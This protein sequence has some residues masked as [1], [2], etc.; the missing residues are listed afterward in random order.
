MCM[1]NRF[2]T[3]GRYATHALCLVSFCGLVWACKDDY[4][5]DDEKPGSLSSS[6][7]SFLQDKGNYQTYIRL[8]NDPAVNDPNARP[9]WEELS[10]TNEKTLFVANDEGWEAFFQKNATLPASDPW[11]TAT[12]YENLS[13]SQKK[14]LIH[15]SML[16]NPIVMENLASEEG[17]GSSSLQRGVYMRRE[18]SFM[19]TDTITFIP[20]EEIPFTYNANDKN[21]WRRFRPGN[22]DGKTG[23]HLV[24]DSTLNMLVFLT[25]EFL[26]KQAITNE[27]FSKVMGGRERDPED[28]FITD[29]RLV[30]KDRVCENG[31]INIAEKVIVPR[32]NM[33]EVIRNNGRTKIYS[34]I[35]D[36]FSYPYYNGY[37]TRLYQQQH[38]EFTDSIFTM[39]YFAENDANH[40]DQPYVLQW[41]NGTDGKVPI[42]DDKGKYALLFDPAWNEYHGERATKEDMAAMFV[43]S[44]DALWEYFKKGGAGRQL[45]DAYSHNPEVDVAKGNYDELYQQID[46]IPL[47]TLQDLVRVLQKP[48]FAGS[49]PSKFLSLRDD[50]NEEMFKPGEGNM[51]RDGGIIDTCIIACN[52]AVYILNTVKGPA[53]YTSVAAPAKISPENHS[54]Y[55]MNW[56]IYDSDQMHL[57]YYAYLKAMKSKFTFFLPSDMSLAHYYDPISFTSQ[58]ARVIKMEYTGTGT[59]PLKTGR[60]LMKYNVDTGAFDESDLWRTDQLQKNE[61]LNRLKDILESHTI[62]MSS[63]TPMADLEDEYFLSRNGSAIKVS[64]GVISSGQNAGKN[65]ISKV[66]GGFQ[67]ENERRNTN[68]ATGASI[69]DQYG[70]LQISI[71]EDN[72]HDMGDA[73][74]GVTYVLDDAAIIPAS[75]SVYGLINDGT[76]STGTI[77]EFAADCNEFFKLTNSSP[78]DKIIKACDLD[79]ATV[80]T[81]ISD[82]GVDLNVKY[83]SNFNYTVLVPTNQAI[84]DAVALGLPTWESIEDYYNAQPTDPEDDDIH[85]LTDDVIDETTGE[86]IQVGTKTIL[87]TMITYLGNFVRTHFIDNSVFAD[88]SAMSDT[89][90]ITSSYDSKLGAFVRVYMQRVKTGGETQLQVRD[91]YHNDYSQGIRVVSETEPG[92]RNIMARDMVCILETTA[93]SYNGK[94]TTPTGRSTLNN[95]VLMSSSSSVIHQINGVICH[96]ELVGGRYDSDWASGSVKQQA[97]RC[98]AYLKRYPLID[99]KTR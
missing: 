20:S 16:N 40:N 35:L 91:S 80:R 41:Y 9:L 96:K 4:I 68:S 49:V 27:D 61:L 86:V 62:V 52:G 57:N 92:P 54:N 66:Q 43:P 53:D 36:R 47:S 67:L 74:N 46:D 33:A 17:S 15:G 60:I 11:H 1:E 13:Q 88:K 59:L 97:Q 82:G 23:I 51:S 58:H 6:L 81:W 32:A 55:I 14:L 42:Q 24:S 70:L 56:A 71:P 93:G 30:E 44:D 8:L 85:I 26:N 99:K 5:L 7:Y 90:F 89:E 25:P 3:F 39:R 37:V 29:A 48:S 31:Y 98:K 10:K 69:P 22:A 45:V 65:Y 38:P 95:I 83:F 87:K 79:P 34:H 75:K 50:A 72:V 19:L 94:K 2:N 21:F 18:T 78:Y 63:E 77:G 73:G 64:R 76:G 28:V 84:Q 12:S